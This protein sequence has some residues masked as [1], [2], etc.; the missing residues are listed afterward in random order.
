MIESYYGGKK[1]T[2]RSESYSLR[3]HFQSVAGQPKERHGAM[4]SVGTSTV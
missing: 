2:T 1:P 4:A 3:N